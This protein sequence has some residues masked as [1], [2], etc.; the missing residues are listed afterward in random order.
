MR[1]MVYLPC[2]INYAE[3]WNQ[4]DRLRDQQAKLKSLGTDVELEFVVSVNSIEKM[5][6]GFQDRALALGDNFRLFKT[7]LADVNINLGFLD[8]IRS[9]ADLFWI[10]SPGDPVSDTALMR[11]HEFF[12]P[13]WNLDFVVADE[14]GRGIRNISLEMKTLSFQTM[15]EASFGMVTGVIYKTSTFRPYFHL[16]VQAAFTGWG[17][18]AVLL[19]GARKVGGITGRILPSDYFYFRGDAKSLSHEEKMENLRSYAHSFF[20]FVILMSLLL[21]NPKSQ[22]RKWVYSNWFR[23]GS[24][25][26]AYER[27]KY[28]YIRLTDLRHLAKISVAETGILTRFLYSIATKISFGEIRKKFIRID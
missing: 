13:K 4:I 18:L 20:G 17:Q 1:L 23:I 26:K 6:T 12:G 28:G 16:G 14:D 5:S 3:G 10:V 2:W 15:S 22:V 7:N 8:A 24:Y 21:P 9:E 27:E 25:I 19:G 11:I